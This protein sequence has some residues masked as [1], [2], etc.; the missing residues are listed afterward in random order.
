MKIKTVSIMALF[1][2]LVL[3]AI[4]VSALDNKVSVA[5]KAQ[6]DVYTVQPMAGCSRVCSWCLK[7][8]HGGVCTTSGACC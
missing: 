3:G 8:G 5:D 2:L 6:E 7:L 4:F 1:A